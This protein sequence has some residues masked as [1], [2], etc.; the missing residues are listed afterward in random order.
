[1][2]TEG[3]LPLAPV[4]PPRLWFGLVASAASWMTLGCL[5]ILITWRACTHQENF[6]IPSVHPGVRILFG[7]VALVLLLVTIAA[8]LTSYRNWRALSGR[9]HVLDTEAIERHEFMA[10]LGVIVSVTLGM[11]IV[12]LALPPLFLDICWRAR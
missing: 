10:L 9:H 1:M 7:I 12:W 8:G 3:R 6:G 5:D 2:A 4:K 11:G